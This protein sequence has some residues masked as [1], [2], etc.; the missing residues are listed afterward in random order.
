MF[1]T[2]GTERFTSV[3]FET[4]DHGVP[5]IPDAIASFECRQ[6]AVHDGGDHLILVGEIIRARYTLKGEP[7]LYFRS[8]YCDIHAR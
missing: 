2:K 8:E 3:P 6:Y 1:A 5:I 7:L 4:W